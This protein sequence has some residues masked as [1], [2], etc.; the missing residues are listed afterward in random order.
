MNDVAQISAAPYRLVWHGP[1][2]LDEP[3]ALDLFLRL[4]LGAY[5]AVRRAY[6]HFCSARKLIRF[7]HL[8]DEW[9][10]PCDITRRDP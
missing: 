7:L 10:R 6:R 3:A 2:R 4:D 9:W 8:G 1:N 5:E